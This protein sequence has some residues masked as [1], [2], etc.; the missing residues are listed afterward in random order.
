M[1]KLILMRGVPGSGKSYKARQILDA[2]PSPLKAICSTDDFRCHTD[3]I[4]KYDGKQNGYMH[5]KN[6]ALVAHL[7]SLDYD[8]IIVDNTNT[9]WREMRKY[10]MMGIMA[11]YQIELVEPNTHW[12][13]EAD[14]C[15]VR[16]RHGVPIDAIRIMLNR[17]QPN[18]LIVEKICLIQRGYL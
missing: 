3:G 1:K 6:H 13:Y 14:E 15:A 16:N 17:Y 18:H 4:Y 11:D 5:G 2:H 10:A 8:L 7:I 12:A 9:T